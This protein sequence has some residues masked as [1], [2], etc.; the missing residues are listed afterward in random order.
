MT[1]ALI[2]SAIIITAIA[3]AL[4][5]I[6]TQ[7]THPEL[8][9]V[10]DLRNRASS[11]MTDK[12]IEFLERDVMDAMKNCKSSFAKIELS[13]VM[14]FLEELKELNES[15]HITH[16]NIVNLA[17]YC[18][19][20]VYFGCDKEDKPSVTSHIKFWRM[21]NKKIKHRTFT[22]EDIQRAYRAGKNGWYRQKPSNEGF[23][24]GKFK[25]TEEE[26]LNDLKRKR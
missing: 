22:I 1:T 23:V 9:I 5:K 14:L 25:G 12:E 24:V 15:E 26:Y 17:E 19:D 7:H 21:M 6:L 11:N 10:V 13:N 20:K 3:V 8:K 18:Y 16:Q 2:V 4:F